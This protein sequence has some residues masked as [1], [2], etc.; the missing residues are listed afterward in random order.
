[1]AC[2]N[3]SDE[4]DS[5]INLESGFEHE[6]RRDAQ[7]GGAQAGYNEGRQLGWTSS[8]ALT[9]EVEFYHGGSAAILA[10]WRSFPQA[11]KPKAVSEARTIV[12]LCESTMLGVRGNDDSMDME[13]IVGEVKKA[14]KVM[15]AVQGLIGVRFESG[16]QS[17]LADLSF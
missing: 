16:A 8:V 4:F 14:F 9:A 17:R 3:E 5:I 7:Q 11:V 13:K 2:S 1:M 6:G 12:Q 15:M 10:L